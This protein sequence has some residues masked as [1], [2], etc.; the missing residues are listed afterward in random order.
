MTDQAK[1]IL[2][3]TFGYQT[4]KPFQQEVIAGVLHRRGQIPLLHHTGHDI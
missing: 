3:E 2:Q 4:F 1:K